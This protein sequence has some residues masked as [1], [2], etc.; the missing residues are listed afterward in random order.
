MQ[1]SRLPVF[2]NFISQLRVLWA[3]EPDMQR[4]MEGSLPLLRN[5]VSNAEM[6]RESAKSLT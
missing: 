1:D 4:R 2:Q 5:L 6:Q 3:S